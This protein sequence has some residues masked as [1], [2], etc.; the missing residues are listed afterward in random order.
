MRK[1]IS[2][3]Q[4]SQKN[5]DYL[6][7]R[8]KRLILIAGQIG[9]VTKGAFYIIL[10]GLALNAAIRTG[11]THLQLHQVLLDILVQPYGQLILGSMILGMAGYSIWR[12]LQSVLDLDQKGNGASG[13]IQR[14]SYLFSAAGYT[15]IAYSSMKLLLGKTSAQAAVSIKKVID[16]IFGWPLGP[17]LIGLVGVI[18]FGISFFQFYRAISGRFR[19]T[20]DWQDIRPVMKQVLLFLGRAGY[21]ARGILYLLISL[22]LIMASVTFHPSMAGGFGTAFQTLDSMQQVPWILGIVATGV[23]FY[24]L[25]A[26]SLARYRCFVANC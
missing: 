9:Y 6:S 21:S 20:M 12:L 19:K 26:V 25:F 3:Q 1:T 7:R 14:V 8:S 4:P 23:I 24:G 5:G 15:A 18:F 13:L 10:G 16:L 17:V 22:S 11:Q 2:D